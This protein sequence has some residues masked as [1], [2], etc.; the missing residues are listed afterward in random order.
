MSELLV[1]SI[2]N[3][4]GEGAPSFPKGATVTGVITATSFSGSGANL[5]GIDA[6][7]LK[8]GSGNVKI[9]ANSDGATVTGVL[10][11]TTGS[12]TGNVSVGGTLTYEDVTNID[13]VGLI[14]ARSG[15]NVTSGDI[16]VTSGNI[17]VGT[18]TTI[19]NSGV[20]VTGVVTAT[21]FA[22][23]GANLT[24]LPPGGNVID[25]VADGAIAAGKACIVTSAGKAKQVGYTYTAVTSAP[26]NV[27]ENS[28]TA[29]FEGNL[30]WSPQ[31]NRLVLGRVITSN[32]NGGVNVCTPST[33][34]GT[35]TFAVGGGHTYDT[36]ASSTAQAYDPDT[37]QVIF[38]WKDSGSSNYG[39][40]ILGTITGGPTTYDSMSFG[41]EVTFETRACDSYN[42]VYDT[43]NNKVVIVYRNDTGVPTAIVGTVSGTSI[44][45][46]TAVE[47]TG[48][49]SG[50]NEICAC[51]DSSNNKVVAF[52]QNASDSDH[53]Y[54]AVAT[55][56]GTSISWGT[57]VEFWAGAVSRVACTFD[58][59][60]NKTVTVYRRN[61]DTYG[62]SK[63]GT[64]SGTSISFGAAIVYPSYIAVKGQS[65]CYE[66]LSNRIF[67]FC[68]SQ[69]NS[70]NGRMVMGYVDGTQLTMVGTPRALQGN[71]EV[72]YSTNENWDLITLGSSGKIA[73]VCRFNSSANTVIF[74]FNAVSAASNFSTDN[75]NFLGFAEDA[76]SDGNTGT[77][78]L[79]G[80][81]VGNQS[82]LTP[83]SRYTVDGDGNLSAG[84]TG[85][86]CGLLA[87]A[88][89]KG[90][91]GSKN[92]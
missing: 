19:D 42:V 5:T 29:S 39:K 77:I 88:A 37:N 70:D 1:T 72:M 56:S 85:H 36:T 13:A 90:R 6:T 47:L 28:I 74:T 57:P 79:N 32:N 34:I 22:G 54:G 68:C 50:G 76:I 26:Q 65:V 7:A 53:G 91:I 51:F 9:Q 30:T 11:A 25:L 63:V 60:N 41:T 75:L 17:K 43:Y 16:D 73:G 58:T 49:N 92:N 35:N 24:N 80:N 8:D 61:S 46:G 31:R 27:T 18:A 84:W 33:T 62:Y 67:I 10:T 71:P 87:I 15:I 89:D 44:S 45:F 40:C 86:A 4:E 23:S 66:H 64:V 12:F 69:T 21:S 2:Y 20:N 83:G 78:K 14:T 59:T 82:G 48:T 55:V 52:F 81:V 38:V 3:Q